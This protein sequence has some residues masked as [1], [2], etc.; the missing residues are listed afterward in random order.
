MKHNYSLEGLAYRLRPV[1]LS[2]AQF[3]IDTRLEDAERNRF[4][5]AVSREVKDQEAWLEDY[6]ERSGDY[7]FIVENRITGAAE[8]VISFYDEDNKMAEWG[9]WVIRKGSLAAAESVYLLYRI[10]FEQAGLQELFCRTIADNTSVVAFHNSIGE[11]PRARLEAFFEL[12]GVRYDAVEQYSDRTHFYGKV[13]PLLER[14]SKLVFKRLIK[15][16]MGE[17]S[18]HHIGIATKNIVKELPVYTLMGYEIESE[19]FEDPK[20]GVRGQF[21]SAECRPRVE[22]LENLS[23]SHTLD[24][25]IEH[26]QKMYHMAFYVKDIENAVKVFTANRAKI[27]SPLKESTYFGKRICFL[28]LPNMSM[29]ELLER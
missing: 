12:D 14:Q 22:L 2:D 7:Y 29:I 26:N 3:I 20:Q 25:Q 9:R 16:Q 21:L 15:K 8:G 10:A 27:I 24:K 19:L 17:F 1:K 18:F 11:K 4:I 13:A 28:M 23:D 5:H 6:F